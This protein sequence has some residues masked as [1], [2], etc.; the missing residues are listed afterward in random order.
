MQIVEI[1][2]QVRDTFGKK[3]NIQLR[4]EGLAPA[5]VY[6]KDGVDHIVINPKDLKTL[7][8]TPDFKLAQLNIDGQMQ[9]VIVKD[10]QF[11][12]V[13]DAILHIDFLRLIDGVSVTCDVPVTFTGDSPG[14]KEG[15][16]I[17]RALRKVT[18]KTIPE[19]LVDQ[20]SGDISAMNLGDSLRIKDLEIPDG[21]E[22]VNNS[23]APVCFVDVPRI[24]K[25]KEEGVGEIAEGEEEV[26]ATED[27]GGSEDAKE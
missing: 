26:E 15:G 24:A 12:P 11:H 20:I 6:A 2:A 13:T 16:Q 17:I 25:L 22:V 19:K 9:K 23:N 14:L 27:A 3:A 18:L 10:I 5:V 1:K 7:I 8:Y 21:I 4:R